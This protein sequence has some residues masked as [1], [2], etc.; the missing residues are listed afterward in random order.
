[1]ALMHMCAWVDA[2]DMDPI[3]ELQANVLKVLANPRRLE[4]VHVLA[5]GPAEV[6]A[7]AQRLG[8]SQPNV[9]QHLAVMRAAG[10]VDATREGREVRYRLADPNVMVACSVMRGVLVRRLDRLA[11]LTTSNTT[12]TTTPTGVRASG[13]DA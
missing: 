7:L 8:V 4:I 5:E 3:Y 11:R 13:G 10:V 12:V 2:P 9:S 6:H 1:V